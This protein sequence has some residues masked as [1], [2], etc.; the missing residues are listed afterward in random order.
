LLRRYS[1]TASDIGNLTLSR[2]EITH[3]QMKNWLHGR[4][5]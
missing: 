5:L 4:T 3:L 1:F 2:A